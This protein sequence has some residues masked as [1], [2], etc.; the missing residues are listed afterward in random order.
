[1]IAQ[2]GFHRWRNAKRLM[3]TNEVA[4]HEMK[5]DGIG[6]V[7]D[8]LG[9]TVCKARE[10]TH[11]H[12]HRQV[13]PFYV[14][15]HMLRVGVTAYSFHV[16][17]DAHGWRISRLC[18]K[19]ST[20]DLVQLSII[21]IYAECAF[22]GFKISLVA[23]SCDLDSSGYAAGAILHKVHGPISAASANEVANNKLC[24]GINANPSP[25]VAPSDLFFLWAYILS[26]CTHVGPNLITLKTTDADVPNI[27]IV[28]LH[29]CR[30]KINKQ[31]RDRISGN[32]SHARST[33]NAIA[34]YE[35]CHD[36]D[37]LI[38]AKQVHTE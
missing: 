30:A 38:L 25:N 13:L 23:I 14:A 6:M 1:M 19:R 34:L 24:V 26:F 5:S 4:I 21:T 3:D 20:V 29:A 8:F 7:V 37:S 35:G 22:D 17:T 28:I 18:F 31:L 11:V 33:A 16:A 27:S 36:S 10:T 15:T 2:P 9:E 32:S 12:S